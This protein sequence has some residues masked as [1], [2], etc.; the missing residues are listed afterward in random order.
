[1]K[2]LTLRGNTWYY[3]KRIPKSLS[4]LSMVNTIYRPLS[5]DKI[6]AKQL[7]ERYDSLFVMIDASI[8]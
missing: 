8:K 4:N 6:L 5:T 3:R 2:H 1:M 7:A